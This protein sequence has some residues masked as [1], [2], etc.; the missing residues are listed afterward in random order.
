MSRLFW[1]LFFWFLL[2]MVATGG[3]SFLAADYLAGQQQISQHHLQRIEA[4]AA[5][6]EAVYEERGSRGLH[7][8]L[9]HMR[10]RLPFPL[11]IVHAA[12]RDHWQDLEGRRPPPEV[13]RHLGDTDHLAGVA[14]SH[15]AAHRV[16]S[17]QLNTAPGLY[18]V[19]LLPHRPMRVLLR[20]QYLVPLI[21]LII[22]I[23]VCLLIAWGITHPLGRLRNAADALAG[24]DL[25]ARA[26]VG[27]RRDAI[28]LL[29][30][31]FNRMAARIEQGMQSQRQLLSDVSHELRSPL[32]RLRVASELARRKAEGDGAA[33]ELARIDLEVARLD[34]M[35]GDVLALARL[36]ND[37]ASVA[38]EPCNVDALLAEVVADAEF[39]YRTEDK[40]VRVTTETGRVIRGDA[41]LLRSAIDNVVRNAMKYTAAGT[42]VEAGTRIEEGHLL[43]E[44]RDHGPG[45]PEAALPRLFDAFYRV[46]EARDRDSGGHGLGL[47]I[48]ARACRICGGEIGAANAPGAGLVVSMAF[49]LP[50]R[51]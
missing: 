9:R 4:M 2:T 51:G 32:A 16:V 42:A 14:Q 1:K 28:G 25:T 49:P 3:L 15:Q 18:V 13:M 30:D 31:D 6:A 38:L 34:A 45:V 22:S 46:D 21:G 19:T 27:R 23:T 44:V 17:V 7:S 11:L 29:A 40:Q 8:W 36:E 5:S 10:Q 12:P 33:A 39:E 24:G 47:A 43:L 20:Y 50:D 26:D 48:A 35:L 41:L 37:D